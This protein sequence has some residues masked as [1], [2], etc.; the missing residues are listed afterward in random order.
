MYDIALARLAET[1]DNVR[2]RRD[3]ALVLANS[4]YALRRLNRIGLARGRVDDALTLLEGTKDYPSDRIAL[5]SELYAVLHA[6]ADQHAD[7][8]H[9]QEAIQ[10]YEQL[11]DKVMAAG[12]DVEH[13]LRDAYALSLLYRG[14]RAP[15]P[16][17]RR[18]RPSGRH[19][20]EAA[21]DL[22]AMERGTPQ[23]PLRASSAGRIH[24][25]VVFLL[26]VPI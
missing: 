22:D 21:C 18:V 24:V 26:T 7:E 12:P 10:Q 8:G 15:L 2:T 19:R 17:E 6:R 14:P 3:R 9:G 20:C 25:A 11:L 13:D 16:R 23:Q 1:R 5:D 4:S